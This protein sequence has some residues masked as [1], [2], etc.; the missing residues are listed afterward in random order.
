[1]IDRAGDSNPSLEFAVDDVLN[2][3]DAFLAENQQ[4]VVHC[5]G[6]RSRTGLVLAAHL[7]RHGMS[8]AEAKTHLADVWPHA[9]FTNDSFTQELERRA[10]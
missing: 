7:M 10:N 5:H 8:W 4:V 3:I 2:S 1:M 6:G 9:H